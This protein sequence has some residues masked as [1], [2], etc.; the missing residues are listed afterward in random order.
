MCNLDQVQHLREP[1]PK[2]PKFPSKVHTQHRPLSASCSRIYL[3][4][5]SY[6]KTCEHTHEPYQAAHASPAP[7]RR[8]RRGSSGEGNGQE[9][10]QEEEQGGVVTLGDLLSSPFDGDKARNRSNSTAG[11]AK[12]GAAASSSSASAADAAAAPMAVEEAVTAAVGAAAEAA[13]VTGGPC[14]VFM[15]SLHAHRA[16]R[17]HTALV[18]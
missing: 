9:Q 17:I 3:H 8:S 14:L 11:A 16:D 1:P 6:T 13:A 4:H 10:E 5:L 18:K 15:D 12:A 2:P 7:S